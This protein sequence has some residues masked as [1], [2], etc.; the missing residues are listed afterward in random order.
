[1]RDPKYSTY[2]KWL[3]DSRS[4][5]GRERFR[6]YDIMLLSKANVSHEVDRSNKKMNFLDPFPTEKLTFNIFMQ[7]GCQKL[8]IRIYERPKQVLKIQLRI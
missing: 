4:D 7:K 6:M 8:E 1:M 5:R 3:N 2:S